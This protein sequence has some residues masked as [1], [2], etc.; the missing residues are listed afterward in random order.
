MKIPIILI[1][2]ALWAAFFLWPLVQRRM[3]GNRRDSVG[4][5]TKKVTVLGR[6][7]GHGPKAAVPAPTFAPGLAS[8][9]PAG[10]ALGAPVGFKATGGTASGLPMSPVAQKR[11]RDALAI[12]AL[13]AVGS[14]VLALVLS[15]L[16][17]WVAHI[18]A[19]LVLVGYLALLVHLRRRADEHRAKVHFLPQPTVSS[20]EAPSP[21]QSSA[22]VLRRSVS[23]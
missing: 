21:R 15:S 13:A 16:A 6:A 23:S 9:R 7:G 2:V 19:D 10:R 12:L 8:A 1:L 11:R 5:F 18:V 20:S 14:L 22:L 17:L 3:G 4:S